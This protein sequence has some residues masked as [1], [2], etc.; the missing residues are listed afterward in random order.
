M[1]SSSLDGASTSVR[2]QLHGRGREWRAKSQE[3]EIVQPFRV[4]NMAALPHAANRRLLRVRACCRHGSCVPI[5]RT[6]LAADGVQSMGRAQVKGP[7]G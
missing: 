6:N 3:A 7:C 1:S 2:S 5:V 4:V